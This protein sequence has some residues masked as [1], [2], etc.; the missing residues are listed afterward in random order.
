MDDS[1]YWHRLTD[2]QTTTTVGLGYLTTN[3]IDPSVSY[4]PGPGLLP[5]FKIDREWITHYTSLKFSTASKESTDKGMSLDFQDFGNANQTSSHV[6]GE[7]TTFASDILITY[8]L[9]N[10]AQFLRDVFEPHCSDEFVSRFQR[11]TPFYLMTGYKVSRN[12]QTALEHQSCSQ[13]ALTFGLSTKLRIIPDAAMERLPG[14]QVATSVT[15]NKDHSYLADIA[16]QA[17]GDSIFFVRYQR[18]AFDPR[19]P[20][21]VIMPARVLSWGEWCTGG[22]FRRQMRT[23]ILA[24]EPDD[25]SGPGLLTTDASTSVA[26][27]RMGA[28]RRLPTTGRRATQVS[29][30]DLLFQPAGQDPSPERESLLPA[31]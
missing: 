17:P 24:R 16:Y 25:D 18:I 3:P 29:G 12:V 13:D 19:F 10:P 26:V 11:G 1:A 23:F 21:L 7:E 5:P 2:Q 15:A 8:K 9:K 6:Q 20:G 27:R 28:A 31:N 22:L 30:D 14:G 4:W